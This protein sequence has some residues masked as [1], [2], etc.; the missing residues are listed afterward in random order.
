MAILGVSV[1]TRRNGI[2]VIKDDELH[3]AQ[4]H[5]LNDRWSNHKCA[6]LIALYHKYVRDYRVRLVIVKTPKPS[7]FTLALK[8]LIR[9]LDAYVKKQGCLVEYTT[10]QQMKAQEPAIKNKRELGQVVA[11]R[12]PILVHEFHR[13]LKLKQPY[14]TKL[15]EAVMA[16]DHARKGE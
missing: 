2:A 4:V 8:Q 11:E 3:A 12:Y 1:G 15:F 9:A 14:Y 6:A 7:H 16:A 10:I 13:E 5:T